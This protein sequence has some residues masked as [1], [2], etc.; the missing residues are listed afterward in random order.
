M[1]SPKPTEKIRIFV[2]LKMQFHIL[3]TMTYRGGMC[4]NI[5]AH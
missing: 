2:S 3:L 1:E 4:Y 5:I